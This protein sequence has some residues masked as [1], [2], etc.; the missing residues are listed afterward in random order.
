MNQM[1][2]S[3]NNAGKMIQ[4]FQA[5]LAE[6]LAPIIDK[7]IKQVTNWVQVNKNG[8]IDGIVKGTQ[9]ILKFV[10]AVVNV[11]TWIGRMVN[12]TIG[13][14]GAIAAITIA[15]GLL[16]KELLMSPIIWII[17][18]ILLLIA[19]LDDLHAALGIEG[20]KRESVFGGIFKSFPEMKK[21]FQDLFDG[22]QG[23]MDFLTKLPKLMESLKK[24]DW[25]DISKL[26]EQ[27]GFFGTL[28]DG[29]LQAITNIKNLLYDIS[30]GQWDKV[31]EDVTTNKSGNYQQILKD[32]AAAGEK[33]NQGVAKGT[34]KPG[35]K[36]S[37]EATVSPF[38]PEQLARMQATMSAQNKN[39]VNVTV[40]NTATAPITSTVDVKKNAQTEAS[41]V[42]ANRR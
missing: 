8:L 37:V 33:Y 4:W 13:W 7:V 11:A 20:D 30:T 26:T 42:Q 10:E 15:W 39:Q 22:F 2:G 29:T 5:L 28:V 35:V 16:N 32:M 36:P 9:F 17:G 14:K 23:F 34:I 1:Q 19:V 31:L 40:K 25:L 6:R 38:T 27:W 12:N 3:L 41:K 24:G 18:G 21:M